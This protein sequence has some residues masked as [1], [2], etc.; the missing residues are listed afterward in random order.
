MPLAVGQCSNGRFVQDAYSKMILG[1]ALVP[2]KMSGCVFNIC[3]RVTQPYIEE[4]CRQGLEVQ[5][6]RTME[7]MM[8]FTVRIFAFNAVY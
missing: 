5:L 4:E 8:D 3:A 7:Q 6:L 2:P 1:I